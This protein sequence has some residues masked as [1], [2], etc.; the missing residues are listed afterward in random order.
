MSSNI[1]YVQNGGD[2]VGEEKKHIGWI[3]DVWKDECGNV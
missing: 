3:I 1:A 2:I